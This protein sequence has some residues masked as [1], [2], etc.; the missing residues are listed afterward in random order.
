MVRLS[1]LEERMHVSLVGL[2]ALAEIEVRAHAALVS[3]SLDGCAAASIAF[4][5]FVNLTGLVSGALA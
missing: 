3:D 5:L 4:N 1:N 2:A